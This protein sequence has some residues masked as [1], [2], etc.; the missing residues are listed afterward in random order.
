LLDSKMAA[1][2]FCIALVRWRFSD[3]PA[4]LRQASAQR[5]QASAQRLQ[6]S[7]SCASHCFAHQSQM[8][9][10][11]LQICLMNGLLRAIASAHKRHIAAH[12]MQ[13]A[14]QAFLLS[15]PTICAKQ[16]PHSVAQ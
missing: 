3:Q 14:G 8:S 5:R 11:S 7:M 16:L 2:R 4:I 13:Q 9:A 15:L 12:S 10:H 6:W 1:M